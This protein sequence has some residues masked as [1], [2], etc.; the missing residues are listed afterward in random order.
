MSKKIKKRKYNIQRIEGLPKKKVTPPE[1]FYVRIKKE[2]KL[3][4]SVVVFKELLDNISDVI[5][6]SGTNH[7]LFGKLFEK[8]RF[9][10]IFFVDLPNDNERDKIFK[11]HL[12]Q[13]PGSNIKPGA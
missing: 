2:N 7:G 1:E 10:E 13:S 6:L 5:L 12:A 4:A 3:I 9:D 8:G 11:I